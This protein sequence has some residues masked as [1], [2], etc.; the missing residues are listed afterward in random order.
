[1]LE[2]WWH[3]L[4]ASLVY[5]ATGRVG[6]MEPTIRQLVPGVRLLGRAYTVRCPVGDWSAAARAVDEAEAGDVVVIDVGGTDRT[7]GWGGTCS[8]FAQRRGVAGCVT[9]GAV[10]DLDEI[11][12]LQFPVYAPGSAVRGA[13]RTGAGS[14]QIPVVVGGVSVHPGDIVVGDAD[15]IVVVPSALESTVK[16]RIDDLVAREA[17]LQAEVAVAT[18]YAELVRR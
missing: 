14:T 12:D 5:E 4:S 2:S 15:G 6:D 3:G 16:D 9:N 10:R 7:V 1:M 13:L 11:R 17:R 18:T 8:A